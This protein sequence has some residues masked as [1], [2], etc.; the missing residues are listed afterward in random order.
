MSGTKLKLK[1][2]GIDTQQECVLFLRFDSEILKSEGYAKQ[3]RVQVHLG[4]RSVVATLNVVYNGLLVGEEASLSECAWERIGASEGAEITLSHLAPLESLRHVR[5]KI[6]G[7]EFTKE[8]LRAILQDII[9]GQYSNIHLSAFVTA[10]AGDRMSLREIRD[11]TEVMIEIGERLDWGHRPIVDK[12][13]VGGLPGNRTTLIVVPIV[14]AAGLVM[15]KTSSRAIT[16]PA[17]T[18]DT[19]E[20]L[21]PVNLSLP[22]M[23]R[24][25]E[26]VGACIA[27]GGYVKLSPA[28]DILIKVERVLDFDS[29]AQLIASVLSKKVSAGSTHVLIDLPVGLTAKVRGLD[30]ATALSDKLTRIGSSVGLTVKC[31]VTDGAQPVGRGIGP[32][33]EAH[34]VLAVLQGD[35]NAPTDLRCRAISLAGSILE[36]AGLSMAGQGEELAE[37]ILNDGRAWKKFQAICEAQGGMRQPGLAGYRHM[38]TAEHSG[39]VQAIDNRQLATIAKLAGA[40]QDPAAG[41]IFL[42]PL[43]TSVVRGQ[44]LYEIHAESAGKLAYALS[45]TQSKAN[46]ITLGGDE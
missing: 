32:A 4:A 23:R 22:V 25:V 15:P 44:S 8:A 33:L 27:W 9:K 7:V 34:D 37:A 10:A 1:R 42:A 46:I 39:L 21:A 5:G 16:S 31:V 14:A 3:T 30:V 45:Y 19:M 24:V 28:D 11:L 2:L 43:G 40:P 18:A 36:M 38:I 12:H 26:K 35:K 29:E 41:L 17:G 20:T 13:C 6:Y